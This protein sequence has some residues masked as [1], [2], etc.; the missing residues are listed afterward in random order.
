LV[1]ALKETCTRGYLAL[2]EEAGTVVVTVD[3][4]P[5]GPG[6]RPAPTPF[7]ERR[8]KSDPEHE[9]TTLRVLQPG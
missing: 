9:L 4:K 7:A 8:R 3:D 5:L 1:Q 6:G 2:V